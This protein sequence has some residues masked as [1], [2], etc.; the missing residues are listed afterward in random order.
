MAEIL[1]GKPVADRLNKETSKIITNLDHKPTLSVIR[2]GENEDDISYEKAIIKRCE[3]N[4][5]N[6]K[7]T[8]LADDISKSDYLNMIKDNNVDKEVDGIILLNQIYKEALSTIS[9]NK[10]IDGCNPINLSSSF[11]NDSNG[12][13]PCTAQAV[14]EMFDYYDIKLEDKNVTVVGRSMTVGKPLSMLLLN[15]N[16]TVTICHSHTNDI[17][18]HTLNSDIVIT[19]IGKAE[20]FDKTY[21][22]EGQVVIDVGINYSEKKQK[23]CGDVLFEEVEQVV[24]KITPVP[25]GVGSVTNAILINH[26]AKAALRNQ[27]E[28]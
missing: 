3:K 24:S 15:K 26:L 11:L 10:D 13:V 1:K 19:A 27:N 23:I 17:K 22:R 25:L 9:V 16:A 4:N 7:C 2:V 14:M 12:F 28:H 5:I 8:L 6:C 20:M 21:F 18:Q